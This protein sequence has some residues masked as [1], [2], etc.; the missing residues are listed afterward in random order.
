MRDLSG[1]PTFY[2][3]FKNKEEFRTK[4]KAAFLNNYGVVIASKGSKIHPSLSQMHSYNVLYC[5]Q[6]KGEVFL[7]LRDPRGWS[8]SCFE[9]MIF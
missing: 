9:I 7:M 5:E 8:L 2:L 4:I 3:D 6:I 1:A